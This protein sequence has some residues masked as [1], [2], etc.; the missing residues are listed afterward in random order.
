MVWHRSALSNDLV[1]NRD[2]VGLWVPNKVVMGNK[3]FYIH[4][5]RRYEQTQRHMWKIGESKP[6]FF[7]V[8]YDR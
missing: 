5:W 1:N 6:M 3:K 4:A 7:Q 8:N 2:A